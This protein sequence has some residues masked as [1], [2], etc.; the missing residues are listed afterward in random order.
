MSA[1]HVGFV[2]ASFELHVY[3]GDSTSGEY[4][5]R[6]TLLIGFEAFSHVDRSAAVCVRFGVWLAFP[7]YTLSL[8]GT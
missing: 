5:A 4:S 6:L 8:A 1:D 7:K 3:D 2:A